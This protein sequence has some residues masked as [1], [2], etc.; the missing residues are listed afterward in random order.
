MAGHCLQGNVEVYTATRKWLS[1]GS[2]GKPVGH[3]V[4]LL[5]EF[6]FGGEVS[7]LLE[8][9]STLPRLQAP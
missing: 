1:R 6:L 2:S 8:S 3:T 9:P 7:S 4:A 5:C